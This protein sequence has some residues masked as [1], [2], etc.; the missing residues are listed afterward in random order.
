L[1]VGPCT[2]A[3][4]A[5]ESGCKLVEEIGTVT[6][7]EFDCTYA[8]WKALFRDVVHRVA[9]ERAD[10]GAIDGSPPRRNVSHDEQLKRLHAHTK[11]LILDDNGKIA[12]RGKVW[13]VIDEDRV[14]CELFPMAWGTETIERNPPPVEFA[15]AE[16]AYVSYYRAREEWQAVRRRYQVAVEQ[17]KTRAG[18]R[19][20]S[21]QE[22]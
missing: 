2:D 22:K 9:K 20:R 14:L 17:L 7:D 15:S 4:V 21:D 13:V 1:F 16:E 11:E 12:R 5:S 8:Q 18:R 10:Q 3:D 6:D 19:K